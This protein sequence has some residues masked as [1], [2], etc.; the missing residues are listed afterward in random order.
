MLRVGLA[1]RTLEVLRAAVADEETVARS[2]LPLFAI[3]CELFL[4][5]LVPEPWLVEDD[6]AM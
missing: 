6:S 5:S 1:E 2:A 4:S 3:Q